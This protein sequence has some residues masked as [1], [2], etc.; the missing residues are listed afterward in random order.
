VQCVS[1]PLKFAIVGTGWRSEFFLR[2]AR[3]SP[4]RL[5]AVAVVART[6]AAAERISTAWNVPVVRTLA[7]ALALEPEFVIA[8]VSWPS[9]PGVVTE[10]VELGAH[11]LAETPPA[12]TADGLRSLWNAV[13]ASGRVQVAEQY[14]LMPGHAARLDIVRSGAI[15]TP[16]SVEIASTHL[17]HATS[18]IRSFLGAGFDE[19]VVSARTFSAPLADP[20]TFDG[21]AADPAPEPRTTTIATLDFGDGR[22]GLYDFVDNQWW[23]PLR[24]RRIVVRGS[25]GEIVDDEVTRLTDEGVIISPISYRRTGI[26]M[27]LEGN[28]VVSASF[29]GRVVY[30]NPWIGTRL[31]EDDIA[32]AS[33]LEETG[34]WARSEGE[35]PY[36]LAE[37]CQDH[38]LGLAIEESARTRTDVRTTKEGWA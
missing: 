26:D 28:E 11:V 9:M 32:V 1:N 6:D 30:R 25:R 2:V 37:A 24:A 17:Y 8:A 29:E 13:G 21:W 36:S 27:N 10:L 5:E 35:G 4:D 16:T 12:P 20:L 23:N 22:M 14:M 19:T 18:I 34:R 33:F 38:L 3:A 31:S 15:G 7:D